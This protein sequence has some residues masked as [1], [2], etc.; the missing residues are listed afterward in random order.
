MGKD[1]EYVKIV[2]VGHVDHG[3]STLIGRLLVDTK[4]V[5]DHKLAAIQA[6]AQHLG[7]DMEYANIMDAFEEEQQQNI[8]IETTQIPFSSS[9]RD[10][11]IIDAPGHKDFLKNMVTGASN[12]QVGILLVDAQES[13]KEQTRRHAYLLRLIGIRHLIVLINKM[14]LINYGQERFLVVQEEITSFLKKLDFAPEA[15]IPIAARLGENLSS[16]SSKMSWYPGRS[17]LETLDQLPLAYQ[18][19]SLLRFPVQDV[20]KWDGK[21]I[22]VG[23]IESGNI[24][25]GDRLLFSPSLKETAVKTIERWPGQ[26]NH[27]AAGECIGITM[28]EQ[29]YVE[30]GDMGSLK[31]PMS[32]QSPAITE[33][34]RANLFWLGK[35]SLKTNQKYIIKLATQEIDGEVVMIKKRIDSST[36]QVLQ[37]NAAEVLMNE[38]AEV[39]VRLK[40]PIAL[41]RF[42]GCPATGRFVIVDNYDVAGGGII[43]EPLE[44]SPAT[45]TS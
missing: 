41:D 23:R 18:K 17:F 27:A 24:N 45:Y 29:I 31:A 34:F 37:E 8:T 11:L 22:I 28:E 40:K 39:I 20:Y 26:K 42:T 13:V 38:T 3:K 21:R 36:L 14:D 7:A 6:V 1:R 2:I 4:A 12:A 25:V 5:P 16:S 15:V 10:Y 44:V 33:E 43:I 19:T 9:T 30:R 32:T 35:E